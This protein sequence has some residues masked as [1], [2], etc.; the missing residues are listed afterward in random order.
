MARGFDEGGFVHQGE[1]LERRVGPF[2]ADPAKFTVGG[3][4]NRHAGRCDGPFP[5]RVEAAAE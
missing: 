5:N 1:R 4:E 3:V 2:G